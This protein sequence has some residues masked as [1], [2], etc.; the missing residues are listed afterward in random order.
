MEADY[1][2]AFMHARDILRTVGITGFDAT[3]NTATLLTLRELERQYPSLMDP[4][5]FQ[6]QRAHAALKPTHNKGIVCFSALVAQVY[7]QAERNT[8]VEFAETVRDVLRLL[9]CNDD[10]RHVTKTLYESAECAFTVRDGAV[11]CA[12]LAHVAEKLTITAESDAL[13]RA[14][15]E[16]V[17]GH[18]QEKELGQFFTPKPLV[19]YLVQRARVCAAT[20]ARATGLDRTTVREL[21]RV[22]DPACGSASFLV[23]AARAGATTV[24]GVEIDPRVSI[25][26]NF[27]VM[28]A[29]TRAS[30]DFKGKHASAPTSSSRAHIHR[31]DFLRESPGQLQSVESGVFGYDTVLANPPFGLKTKYA[32]VV[33]EGD[34]RRKL[35]SFPISSSATGMFLQ[36]IVRVLGVGGMG[37]VVLPLGNELA[38]R[39][40]RQT[41]LR[42]ALLRA[43]EVLEIVSVPSGTFQNTGIRTAALVFVKRRE[44]E[45]SSP[46]EFATRKVKLVSLDL[47]GAVCAEDFVDLATIA[48]K[49]YSL[50]PDDYA[51]AAESE[52]RAAFPMVRL[53][54][55]CAVNFG[56]R[57]TKATT[58]EGT[59]PVY[60]G[61]GK[62]FT[63]S[64]HNRENEYVVS[65]FGMS[66]KC[67]RY[68]AGKFFLN[69]SGLTLSLTPEKATNAYIGRV[70]ELAYSTN[71]YQ[72]ASGMAQKNLN[73][74][75][76][77]DIEIPL[78]PLDVQI[79]IATEMDAL[80]RHVDGIQR[81]ILDAS[82]LAER[83][84]RL[85]LDAQLA[86]AFPNVANVRLG[87]VCTFKAGKSITKA[88]LREGQFPVVGGGV[89]PMGYHAEYNTDAGA[90]IVSKDG[91]G[92]GFVSRYPT[93][94]ML[95]G[96]GYAVSYD[97][98]RVSR[99]YGFRVMK[100]HAEPRMMLMHT[101]VAQPALD[102]RAALDIEI[103]LPP[104]DVQTQLAADLDALERE[105]DDA[106]RGLRSAAELARRAIPQTLTARLGAAPA[107]AAATT[108]S[109]FSDMDTASI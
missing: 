20:S 93:P 94:I 87:D 32:D 97:S 53:G 88:Q 108:D 58:V 77:L 27:A 64:T 12:L 103:P 65:R 25:V 31:A 36:R 7:E 104:L 68:V 47:A 80:E 21:G 82:N 56:T 71:V 5:N 106:N 85:A 83:A 16:V 13:G 40:K 23:S 17:C 73:T 102:L 37:L 38:S 96:H 90:T 98:H 101:G 76:F 59:I 84:I 61:G 44:L 35:L 6:L 41:E 14:Y 2:R 18:A 86:A 24:T 105:V 3:A 91:A 49:S 52:T 78:P 75:K 15:M 57:I 79:Q 34:T 30:A 99:E 46:H 66:P 89:S 100:T 107:A 9:Q 95:T 72:C 4:R 39:Q 11:A 92:A 55:I 10:T 70:L 63:T 1:A 19:S 50:S 48:S 74:G 51:R 62:T 22:L 67:V 54:D 8:S 26:A 42:V 60:G 28:S 29:G 33:K 43:V 69:D 45:P 81:G 109:D